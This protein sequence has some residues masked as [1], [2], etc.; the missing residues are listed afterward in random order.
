MQQFG[1]N[2]ISDHLTPLL[3]E[4]LVDTVTRKNDY[5]DDLFISGTLQDTQKIALMNTYFGAEKQSLGVVPFTGENEGKD[6]EEFLKNFVEHIQSRGTNP[7]ERIRLFLPHKDPKSNQITWPAD[8][9]Y[10]V[11]M[12]AYDIAQKFER[13]KISEIIEARV[14]LD[15]DGK[16]RGLEL[17]EKGMLALARPEGG[18]D[19]TTY[20]AADAID[21][22]RQVTTFLP[23]AGANLDR[24]GDAVARIPWQTDARKPAYG[25]QKLNA[26]PDQVSSANQLA[27]DFQQKRGLYMVQQLKNL[28]MVPVGNVM[29]DSVGHAT[30]RIKSGQDT[31]LVSIDTKTPLS[32]K[33]DFKFTF[34]DKPHAGKTFTVNEDML[35]SAFQNEQGNFRTARDLYE[36]EELCR[37]LDVRKPPGEMPKREVGTGK[38][39]L[40][41]VKPPEPSKLKRPGI[42]GE[43]GQPVIPQEEGGAVGEEITLPV[44]AGEP[45][46]ERPVVRAPGGGLALPGKRMTEALPT[47]MEAKKG[48]QEEREGQEGEEAPA[49]GAE[50][51]EEQ[52]EEQPPPAPGRVTE[53]TVA[54]PKPKSKIPWPAIAGGVTGGIA[55]AGF[56]GP[57]IGGIW[58]SS[59][60]TGTAWAGAIWKIILFLGS[61]GQGPHFFA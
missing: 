7:E 13:A 47:P 18:G 20:V 39:F 53:L 1:P 51:P 22:K 54:P 43:E 23:L 36:D 8:I 34:Q 52:P 29:F 32:Q 58:E 21:P 2:F 48:L 4:I 30:V 41:P 57:V 55:G 25:Q 59:P 46:R 3:E 44:M 27:S 10:N 49:G 19:F 26:I 56:V 31:L 50:I 45:P 33:L 16:K 17:L 40:M 15:R 6:R 5:L 28:G 9:K 38:P 35:G 61:H 12:M 60:D 24:P 42:E 11:F 37:R 14:D